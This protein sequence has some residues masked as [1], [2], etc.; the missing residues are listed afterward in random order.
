MFESALNAGR[1]ALI[2]LG[3]HPFRA[4]QQVRAF[5][6]HDLQSLEV[7]RKAWVEGGL[8]KSYYNA[9]RARA[10]ELS[11]VMQSDRAGRHD[12]SERGW[13]PPP[14]GDAAQ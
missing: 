2:E 13:T 4:E 11:K 8:D 12:G 6:R 9:A 3:H 5:R 10:D 1:Q 14:K 7:L